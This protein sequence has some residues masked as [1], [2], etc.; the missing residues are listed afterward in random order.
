MA[1]GGVVLTMGNRP[2]ELV[3]LLDSVLAQDGG[4]ARI[5]VVGNGAPLPDLPDGV[6]TLKLPTTSAS[7][8]AATPGS[9]RSARPADV[10]VAVYLD[11][12]GLVPDPTTFVRLYR[13]FAERPDLGI[14][15]FR[16]ADERGETRRR[17]VPRLGA[18]GALRAGH[19]T[20]FVGG[21][22]AVR[23][24]VADQTGDWPAQFSSP[25]RG[26][27]SPGAPSMPDG[28][29][30]TGRSSCSITRAPTPRATRSTTAPPPATASGSPAATFPPR[31]S[32]S[33]SGSGRSAPSPAAHPSRA[34]AH[35][36]P[37]SPKAAASPARPG[38]PM[39]WRTVWR[40]TRLGRP[41]II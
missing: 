21:G 39:R 19:V 7:R 15:P 17:H 26:P 28:P 33:T 2:A 6:D 22:N 34:F 38:R 23:M 35:G 10:D 36:S 11:D 5:V 8:A 14:V 30:S 3:K 41:P 40:M 13:L 9:T 20:T 1:L 16:I 27:M 29:S 31:S 24:A 4:P 37:A 32:P 18:R 12:D 25:T